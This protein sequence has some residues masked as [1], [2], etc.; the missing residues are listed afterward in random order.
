MNETLRTWGLRLL[1]LGLAIGI[2]FSASVEDR[3]VSSERQVEA[4][5]S[6]NRP[7]GFLILDP[8][9]TVNVRLL[10][11]KN[12]IRQLNPSTVSVQVNL[13]QGEEGTATVNLSDDDV[14]VPPGLEVVSIEPNTIRVQMEQEVTQRV[15]VIPQLVGQPA[16]G[17]SVEEPEVFPNQ[18]LVS[19]PAS[20]VRDLESLTTRPVSLNGRSTTFEETVTVVVANPLIQIV[21]PTT[22]SVRV[23]IKPPQVAGDGDEN[24]KEES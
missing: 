15:P 21:Q 18:V 11:S 2:W 17:A 4:S 8:I 23:P 24:G 13:P 3:L 7:R 6:Y 19:G 20:M 12:A 22:V 14:L 5:V 16:E 1:A 9:R 10:G